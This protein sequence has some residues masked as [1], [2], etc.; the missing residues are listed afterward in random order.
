MG[1]YVENYGNSA[2]IPCLGADK[3]N[4]SINGANIY[5]V[6]G[7]KSN[8][9]TIERRYKSGF[10]VHADADYHGMYL[11]VIYTATPI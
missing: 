6:S 1:N 4:I 11:T 9:L 5:G 8:E 10:A 2:F 7:D 3:Y